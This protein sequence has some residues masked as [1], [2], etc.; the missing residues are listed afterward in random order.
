MFDGP[1]FEVLFAGSDI[2]VTLVVDGKYMAPQIIRTAFSG[3][4]PGAALSAPNSLVRFDFG[5]AALRKVSV[6]ARSSQGPCSIIVGADDHLTPWDRSGEASFAAMADSYGGAFGPNWGVSGPFWEAAALLGIP[7]LDLDAAGGTG[8]G[9]NNANPDT[10][11]PGNAFGAR[12][13]SSVNAQPDL[14]LTAGG[15]NDNN[16]IPA[17]PLYATAAE[18]LAGFNANVTAYYSD[19]R[20]ALPESVLA[21]S[22]PWAPR[23]ASPTDP[24]AQSK[25]DTIKAALQRVGGPWVFLDNL[26]GGWVNSSG[27]SAPPNGPWQTGTGNSSV[28]SGIGNGDLYLAGDG[29]HPN[30]EGCL[31]LGTRIATDLRAALLAL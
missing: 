9:P 26:N 15:I 21:A 13:P 10:R 2:C 8:Y 3:G 11:N 31:Y 28:P 6:Y 24:V 7:H 29:V 1:A 14:F 4:M 12:L 19:L 17:P 20:T 27:A 22:G 18:A 25:A 16:S 5:S 23:A 30:L